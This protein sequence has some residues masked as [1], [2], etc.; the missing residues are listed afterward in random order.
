MKDEDK[1]REQLI[2]EI[3][4]LRQ[5]LGELKSS[6]EE[7]MKSEAKY[8]MLAEA[9][10]AFI[11]VT[12]DNKFVY[13]NPGAVTFA[14]YTRE[15][16]MTMDFW[17]P[18]H[19]EFKEIVKENHFLRQLGDKG[20]ERYEFKVVAKNGQEHWIELNAMAVDWEGKPAVAALAYDITGHKKTEEELH[21]T[22]SILEMRVQERTAE[23][24][25][26]NEALRVEI[27][28]RRQTEDQLRAAHQQLSEIIEFLP[29]ATFV[30][31]KGRRVIAW[32]KAIEEMTGVRKEEIIGKG[33][34]AYAVPFYGEP[35]PILID[36]VFMEDRETAQKYTYTEKAGDTIYAEAFIPSLYE[37]RGVYFLGKA[38]P[39]YSSEGVVIGAIESIRDITGRKR[40]EQEVN[41]QLNFLQV[42]IDT[43]PTP[44]YYKDPNEIYLGCNKAYEI[45]LDQPKENIVG[46]TAYDIWPKEL[47]DIYHRMDNDLLSHSGVQVFD[48]KVRF[49][50]GL[51][52]D[53]N[54]HKATYRNLTG[55]L[56]GLV[57]VFIDITERKQI[58]EMLRQTASEAAGSLSGPS[59]SLLQ[60][61]RR[62]HIPGCAGRPSL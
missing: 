18:I 27:A 34:H 13:I 11:H 7:L 4:E 61:Q 14:G 51:I 58:E 52:H 5:Q 50:D 28:E 17:D 57:G 35:R 45:M 23:L 22:Y 44:I 40:A 9:T 55:Q 2:S 49:A 54:F 30:I 33:N 47:A 29:D 20:P 41:E 3:T 19:P 39:L 1:P 26:A 16:L 15:E 59:G 56:A 10:P 8:R 62:W 42:L 37:G 21:R 31:D 24:A 32:N 43:I 36:L 46:K 25:R 12:Q 6:L 48:S 38:S 60:A 53:V